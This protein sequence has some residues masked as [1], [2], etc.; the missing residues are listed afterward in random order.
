ML[1]FMLTDRREARDDVSKSKALTAGSGAA[2]SAD[3]PPLTM[4]ASKGA[5]AKVVAREVQLRRIALQQA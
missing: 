4:M 3:P 5:S 1:A 2:F